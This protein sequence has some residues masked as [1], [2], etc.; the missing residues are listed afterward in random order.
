VTDG[1]GGYTE[2]WATLA[3]V[4]GA[5]DASATR[6]E[7]TLSAQVQTVATTTITIPW[8]DGVT[9]TCRVVYGTRVFNV[10]GVADPDTRRRELVLA[11][12]E[13]A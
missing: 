13:V 3:T 7:R 12:E 11:C 9:P 8:V 2:T 10:R 5:L 6:M 4:W 1:A